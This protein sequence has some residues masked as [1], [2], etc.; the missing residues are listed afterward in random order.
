MQATLM[1]KMKLLGA[2]HLLSRSGIPRWMFIEH[3][4][5]LEYER[6]AK[7]LLR[8]FGGDR[9]LNAK[10]L[11]RHGKDDAFYEDVVEED[12]GVWNEEEW[13]DV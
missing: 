4:C 9:K 6:V 1:K 5:G 3:N 10:D 13:Q 12:E 11:A 7:A 2:W 8:V